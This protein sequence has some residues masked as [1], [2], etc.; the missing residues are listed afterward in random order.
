MQ[1]IRS[2]NL[3]GASVILQRRLKHR[4][5]PIQDSYR[6]PVSLQ[7][8]YPRG[9]QTAPMI[10]SIPDHNQWLL[11][12]GERDRGLQGADI[13]GQRDALAGAHNQ[14]QHEAKDWGWRLQ[15][16]LDVGLG[17]DG[18]FVLQRTSGHE[19]PSGS[20]RT[21]EQIDIPYTTLVS[22]G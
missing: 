10:S 7:E 14:R 1:A 19:H 4:D 5:I 12:T 9:K 20:P 16:A 2:Q 17:T 21:R 11:R 6:T 22:H 3:A 8:R 18:T 13:P 15:H